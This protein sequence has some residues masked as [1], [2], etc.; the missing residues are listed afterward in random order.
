M[1]KAIIQE[2]KKVGGNLA[3]LAVAYEKL[4]AE[5]FLLKMELEKAKEAAPKKETIKKNI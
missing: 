2:F 5:N 1:N 4:D 3:L